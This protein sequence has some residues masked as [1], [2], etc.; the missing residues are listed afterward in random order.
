MM[1]IMLLLVVM[2]VALLFFLVPMIKMVHTSDLSSDFTRPSTR[3][4]SGELVC[5]ADLSL[6]EQ[7]VL[8]VQ[9]IETRKT[10][11]AMQIRA[12]RI[13]S[14]EQMWNSDIFSNDMRHHGS[15]LAWSI[16]I[17]LEQFLE[18]YSNLPYRLR[19]IWVLH[20]HQCLNM[21]FLPQELWWRR[22]WEHS[23]GIST[24]SMIHMIPR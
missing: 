16:W 4:P 8:H 15:R 22:L 21:C 11:D 24:N 2:L 3:R 20:R 19:C 17:I 5:R 7:E 12:G 6:S 1:R 13:V 18:N 10:H 23:Y 14:T 9:K